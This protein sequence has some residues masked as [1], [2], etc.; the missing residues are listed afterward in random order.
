MEIG[1]FQPSTK[2]EPIKKNSAQLITSARGPP[3]TKSG[4]NSPT[5]GSAQMGE[6]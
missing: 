6:M 4:T 5:D 3:Y 2:P 1:K